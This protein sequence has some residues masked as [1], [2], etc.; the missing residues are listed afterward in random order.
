MKGQ[1]GSERHRQAELGHQRQL[2]HL[3]SNNI[4][5]PWAQVC[6]RCL[7]DG[8]A[9]LMNEYARQ[10]FQT[11]P[12]ASEIVTEYNH[13]RQINSLLS[14]GVV[15]TYKPICLKHG[16]FSC[17]RASSQQPA[18]CSYTSV[19]SPSGGTEMS[20]PLQYLGFFCRAGNGD[21][22]GDVII[23]RRLC[24]A[25][26]F[27]SDNS[28]RASHFKAFSLHLLIVWSTCRDGQIRDWG[29]EL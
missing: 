25:V 19:S 4:P 18:G 20:S 17:H 10:F 15:S 2:P 5:S 9:C 7:R 13:R 1:R 22:S 3:I 24:T 16:P 14:G 11:A 12:P 26:L 21:V 29:A 8:S 28:Q 27:P 23:T 6:R